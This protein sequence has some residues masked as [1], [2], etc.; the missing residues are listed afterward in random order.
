MKPKVTVILADCIERGIDAGWHRAH[1]HV[2]HP[3]H[4]AIKVA[5]ADAIWLEI[6]EHF[7][8]EDTAP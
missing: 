8:M 2:D 1:K 5:I 3:T 7:Y 4:A 6:H